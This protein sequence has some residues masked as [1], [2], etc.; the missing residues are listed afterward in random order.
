M[1]EN[2]NNEKW[3]SVFLDNLKEGV[4]HEGFL[5]MVFHICWVSAVV[6]VLQLIGFMGNP[7]G[8]LREVRGD[9]FRKD[10]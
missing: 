7:R 4:K 3:R 9:L 8:Y 10:D 6:V 2:S 1:V 5:A